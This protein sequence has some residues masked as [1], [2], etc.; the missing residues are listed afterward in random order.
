MCSFLPL[1]I[2]SYFIESIF[3]VTYQRVSSSRSCFFYPGCSAGKIDHKGQ[4]HDSRIYYTLKKKIEKNFW[5]YLTAHQ[6]EEKKFDKNYRNDIRT[7]TYILHNKFKK[8]PNSLYFTI[9]IFCFS[10][11]RNCRTVVWIIEYSHVARTYIHT[12]V[13]LDD[14]IVKLAKENIGTCASSRAYW[15]V[16]YYH[17]LPVVRTITWHE[18]ERWS[19][20]EDAVI[21]L[22]NRL[23][24]STSLYTPRLYS[25]S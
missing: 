3:C 17:N 14:N 6:K 8:Q 1:D 12:Y 9:S 20:N 11:I 7:F 22:E 10:H 4:Y 15:Y 16:Q 25:Y 5:V 18:N 19:K 24:N 2:F 13:H 23:A 21:C